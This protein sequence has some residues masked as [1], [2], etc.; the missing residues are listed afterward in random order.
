MSQDCSAAIMKLRKFFDSYS[1]S[2]ADQELWDMF[3]HSMICHQR[4][5]MTPQERDDH[6]FFYTKLKEL[7]KS[8][9]IVVGT[10]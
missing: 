8:A 10:K 5:D 2:E 4:N 3:H 9:A 7:I 6:F 1:A